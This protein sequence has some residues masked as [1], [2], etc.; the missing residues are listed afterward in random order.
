M[1]IELQEFERYPEVEAGDLV[2]C[3][4]GFKLLIGTDGEYFRLISIDECYISEDQYTF[5]S[6]IKELDYLGLKRVI[7]SE[8][9]KLIEL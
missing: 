2:V 9:L 4:N 6:L 7:K 5:T 3:E 8:N 1:K